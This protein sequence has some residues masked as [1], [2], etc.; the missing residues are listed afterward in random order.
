[1]PTTLLSLV[2]WLS[3]G[4]LLTESSEAMRGQP[5]FS[6]QVGARNDVVSVCE[7]IDHPTQYPGRAI[8]IKAVLVENNNTML[9]DGGGPT[10]YGPDCPNRKRIV[11]IDWSSK[12][13]DNSTAAESLRDI[14]KHSDEFQVSRAS[15]VMSGTLSGFRKGGYGHLGE[16]DLLFAVDDVE[17]AE[18]IPANAPWPKR[19]EAAYRRA[20]KL[21]LSGDKK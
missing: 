12:S 13:Y 2:L 16:L 18:P 5:R 15:V 9:V 21:L 20:R 1:M 17:S 4:S 11:G 14:R 19:I 3:F 8:R 7:L 6:Q 10:L